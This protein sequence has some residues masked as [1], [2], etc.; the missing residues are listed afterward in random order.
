MRVPLTLSQLAGVVGILAIIVL[1]LVPG[2]VRPHTS[3]PGKLEHFIAYCSTAS[4]L[5]F[6]FRSRS[7]WIAIILGLA[8]LATSMEILQLWA[9]GRHSTVGDAIASSFGGVVGTMLG[10][11]LVELAF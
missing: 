2:A 7:G 9:P 5:A 4:A 8:M 1:S 11:L 6:G 3:L 10:G